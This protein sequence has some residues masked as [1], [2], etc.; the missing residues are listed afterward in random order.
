MMA[1]T[2]FSTWSSIVQQPLRLLNILGLSDMPLPAA[3]YSSHYN[4]YHYSYMH[5]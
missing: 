5:V 2:S 4:S 3:R 1:G